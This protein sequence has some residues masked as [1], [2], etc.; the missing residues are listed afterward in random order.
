MASPKLNSYREVS[1]TEILLP[2]W[3]IQDENRVCGYK[4]LGV[5]I[6][7]LVCLYGITVCKNCALWLI[8]A[9]LLPTSLKVNVP[10]TK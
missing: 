9:F 5:F 3:P 2:S 6:L 4:H 7:S 1:I 8:L 10:Q